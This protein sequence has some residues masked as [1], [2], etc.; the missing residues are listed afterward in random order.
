M[1][2]DDERMSHSL[3]PGGAGI[4]VSDDLDSDPSGDTDDY[5]NS[6]YNILG[7]SDENGGIALGVS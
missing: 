6:I 7:S 5:I 1:M 4:L 2:L 3:E